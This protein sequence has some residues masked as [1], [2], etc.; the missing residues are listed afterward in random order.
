M[1]QSLID[2]AH[3]SRGTATD[4]DDNNNN[5]NTDDGVSIILLLLFMMLDEARLRMKKE[6]TPKGLHASTG[7]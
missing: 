3:G 2:G 4:D 6:L 5:N 7:S 1:L